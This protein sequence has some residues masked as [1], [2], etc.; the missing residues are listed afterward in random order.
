MVSDD[1]GLAEALGVALV[2]TTSGCSACRPM[3]CI[4]P[5]IVL[6]PTCAHDERTARV[7]PQVGLSA[8]VDWR[9]TSAGHPG[10]GQALWQLVRC[11][12]AVAGHRW[13]GVVVPCST[14][15]RASRDPG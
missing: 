7:V 13:S 6:P 2:T 11:P 1:L 12:M 4:E 14:S 10:A 5:A 8:A 9:R 3:I 15:G